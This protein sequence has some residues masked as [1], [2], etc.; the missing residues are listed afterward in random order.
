MRRR[1]AAAPPPSTR[2]WASTIFSVVL[3]TPVRGRLVLAVDP[4]LLRLSDAQLGALFGILG[5][6]SVAIPD[7]PPR[8]PRA[9]P[10]TPSRSGGSAL[11][12]RIHCP[13][14]TLH[15]IGGAAAWGERRPPLFVLRAQQLALRIQHGGRLTVRSLRARS[16]ASA[17]GP[18]PAAL[19]SALDGV[20]AD[21]ADDV[22]AG[23]CV[24]AARS[25]VLGTCKL[26]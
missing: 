23:A 17:P 11:C 20:A 24:A 5:A 25:L 4:P 21:A 10:P 22:A 18:P 1:T 12:V 19:R 15:L 6:H 3:S 26:Y 2:I 8:P 13:S 9:A 7:A 16:W 14:V